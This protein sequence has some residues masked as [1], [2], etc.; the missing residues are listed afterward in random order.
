M[1]HLSQNQVDELFDDP[2]EWI[3]AE[4]RQLFRALKAEDAAAVDVSLFYL[5]NFLVKT[6]GSHLRQDPRW[7]SSK[8]WLDSLGTRPPDI[9]PPSLFRLRDE[10]VWATMPDQEHWYREPFEFELELSPV[11]GVF[12]SYTF[13][14][15]D[16]RPLAE[17]ALRS[18]S[19]KGDV[20]DLDQHEWVFVFHHRREEKG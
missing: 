10:L 5:R 19:M 6:L 15:A 4:V 11:T 14:F 8:Q 7:D 9:Q 3:A 17:K 13:R 12:Q 18:T 20:A 2:G 16:H 1:V